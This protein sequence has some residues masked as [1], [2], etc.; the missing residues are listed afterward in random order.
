MNFFKPFI[1]TKADGWW[2]QTMWSDPVLPFEL[3]ER[4]YESR[5]IGFKLAGLTRRASSLARRV[6]RDWLAASCSSGRSPG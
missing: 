4:L 2:R 6:I 1:F 3:N 5:V